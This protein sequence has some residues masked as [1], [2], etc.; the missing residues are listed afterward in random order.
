MIYTNEE[1]IFV[2]VPFQCSANHYNVPSNI[3]DCT[4]MDQRLV[5]LFRQG[6]SQGPLESVLETMSI[7]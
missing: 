2:V 3:D 7:V 5:V 1:S 4:I 6:S